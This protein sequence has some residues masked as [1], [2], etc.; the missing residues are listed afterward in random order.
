MRQ[1]QC[2]LYIKNIKGFRKAKQNMYILLFQNIEQQVFDIFTNLFLILALEL[3]RQ[4]LGLLHQRL[5]LGLPLLLEG[6]LIPVV[7]S[8]L[9]ILLVFLG[10]TK[11]LF[12]HFLS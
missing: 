5:F 1:M 7:E 2:P 4:C 6:V 12:L 9:F 11:L 8:V 10:V 3:S